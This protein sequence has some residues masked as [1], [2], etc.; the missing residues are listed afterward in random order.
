LRIIHLLNCLIAEAHYYMELYIYI[1]SII[2]FAAYFILALK[3]LKLAAA[4][5]PFAFP[6]YLIKFS[7]G[8]PFTFIEILIYIC[9][10]AFLIK[11]G[12]ELWLTQVS[13]RDFL[14]SI[15]FPIILFVLA[16]VFAIFVMPDNVEMLNGDIYASRRVALGIFKGWIISPILFFIIFVN[17]LKEAKYKFLA[18]NTYTLSAVI[19]SLMAIYQ[20]ISGGFTTIDQRASGPFESANYLALYIVPA[21]VYLGIL[22]YKKIIDSCLRRNDILYFSA[23]IIIFLGII[24]SR[25]YAG[26]IA[27]M[28]TFGLFALIEI[29]KLKNRKVKAGIFIGI[30]VLFSIIIFSQIGTDKFNTFL[31]FSQRNSTTVRLQVWET[32]LTL[33]SKNIFFGLGLGQF[34]PMYQLNISWVLGKLP[35]EWTML[36]PHNIFLAFLFYTGIFGLGAFLFII[37][38]FFK[39]V[40][41]KTYK[42]SETQNAILPLNKDLALIALFMIISILL[43]G[44][45]DTPFWKNDLSLLFFLI[46]GT[47]L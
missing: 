27:V 30:I 15:Y 18:L 29:F 43:H 16:S 32:A 45:F 23:F 3:N 13:L 40:Y 20:Q 47:A 41:L 2:I 7:L 37:F 6:L 33:V 39:T 1:I 35:Y 5:L 4:I 22:L 26:I 17:V 19:L 10:L 12:R 34:E 46:L 14:Q 21:F 25:S 42:N 28:G 11:N 36:H 8:V 38:R 9:F 31:D 44:L 24:F